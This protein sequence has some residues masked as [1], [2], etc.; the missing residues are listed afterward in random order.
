M[1]LLSC[2]LFTNSSLFTPI[3]KISLFIYLI[4]GHTN[5]RSATSLSIPCQVARL[6]HSLFNSCVHNTSSSFSLW[7]YISYWQEQI[8]VMF[9]YWLLFVGSFLTSLA[10]SFELFYTPPSYPCPPSYFKS[11][12]FNC[13]SLYDPLE[14]VG[15]RVLQVAYAL[16]CSSITTSLL[17]FIHPPP[18]QHQILDT[19]RFYIMITQTFVIHASFLSRFLA[20]CAHYNLIDFFTINLY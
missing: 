6:S 9:C 10:S 13:T 1:S 16:P 14:I 7:L 18:P 3:Q 20:I 8:I 17:S 11:A 15:S 19:L 4:N 12:G 5:R 2:L